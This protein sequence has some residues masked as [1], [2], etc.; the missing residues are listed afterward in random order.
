[1][2]SNNTIMDREVQE[3]MDDLQEDGLLDSTIIIFYS[4]HGGPLPRGKREVLESGTRVPFMVRFPDGRGAG[5]VR[6]DLCSFV[7]IPATILSL[8]GVEVPGYM[9]GR[10]FWGEQKSPPREYV[11]AARDRLD[12]QY[13]ASRAVRDKR[14]KYIRNFMT[15]RPYLQPQYRDGRPG[16]EA[17]RELYA[18]REGRAEQIPVSAHGVSM[19]RLL[20]RMGAAISWTRAKAD[21]RVG[22]TLFIPAIMTTFLGPNDMALTRFP[23]GP[24]CRYRRASK[25][26]SSNP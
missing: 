8:A 22:R 6:S 18:G 17:L 21:S 4:D 9:Q 12:A 23:T 14:F 10:P 5:S 15:D 3:I 2:H 7:D 1:M 13:D 25:N 16:L 26:P 24:M 19:P 20:A 11:Y